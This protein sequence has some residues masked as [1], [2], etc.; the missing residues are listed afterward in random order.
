MAPNARLTLTTDASDDAVGA[1]LHQIADGQIQPLGFYSKK[2]SPSQ[3]KYSAYD[4][5]LT[6]IYQVVQHFKYALDGREFVVFTDHKPIVFAFRQKSERASPRRA[7][8]LDFIG[9]YTTDIQHLPGI[10]NNVAD[11]LSRINAIQDNVINFDEMAVQQR[12]DAELQNIL[13]E[14]NNVSITLTKLSIPESSAELYCHISQNRIRPYVPR[15]CRQAIIRKLHSLSHP[16]IRATGKLVADHYVW[17]SM[18]KDVANYVRSCIPCQKSKV[19]RHTKSP[20]GDYA[21]IDLRFEHINID[22]VGPLPTSNGFR[23]CL[24][25]ID[26][27]SRWPVAIPMVDIT[28]QNVANA[29]ISGWMSIYGIPLRITTDLGR[30][31]ESAI[32]KE[33][34]EILGVRHFRTTPYHP[35]SNGIIERW[36]RTL[37][38]SIKC[39]DPNNWSSAL[40]LVLL[41]MR[42]TVKSDIGLSPAEM[43]FGS[44]LRI[45]GEL[46]VPRKS[47][48]SETEFAVSLRKAMQDL[49]LTKP[50]RHGIQQHFIHPALKDCKFVFVRVDRVRSPLEPSYEGPYE[51]LSK[52]EKYF[53]VKMNQRESKISIDRLKSAYI[54]ND[55]PDSAEVPQ[56]DTSDDLQHQSDN[57][58]QHNT[59]DELQHHSDNN[60]QQNNDGENPSALADDEVEDD[61]Q[62]YPERMTSSGRHVRFPL[63]YR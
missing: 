43:V 40:P 15:T 29:L 6:A 25:C 54:Y 52:N 9:Q 48:T 13:R 1:V 44:P 51:V 47:T 63:R 56:H 2:L 61:S 45:P 59:S 12:S 53:A 37:K 39:S 36:H 5:E 33:L 11:L 27:F 32:F 21:T 55:E 19:H 42:T 4:R 3:K 20:L 41:G 17:P 31:F 18:S 62:R 8:Q 28:A 49:P 50:Q 23:Y 14:D 38:A 34:M 26:R 10:N 7:R 16:G 24:T 22:I 46:L 58:Q 57:S 30:Q 60:P 35:Q